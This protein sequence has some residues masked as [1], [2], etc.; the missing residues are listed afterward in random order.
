MT[1]ITI[2]D[3]PLALA[4]LRQLIAQ[5]E[6]L[7]L[8]GEFSDAMKAYNFL[9]K[10]TVDLVFL[11]VEMPGINGLELVDAL[12]NPPLI[13]VVSAKADYALAAFEKHVVDYLV[14]PVTLTRFISAITFA[15]K[16]QQSRQAPKEVTGS[17]FVKADGRW[18][19]V[20]I[21]DIK[22]LQA[23]GDYVRIFTATEKYMV[24]K[25]MKVILEHLPEDKFVRVHRSY[26]VN[27]DHI[28]NIEERTIV[29]DRDVIP[30]SE[31][32]KADFMQHLNLL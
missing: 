19:K 1:C 8:K 32:H 21:R 9:E 16:I 7:Q 4:S 3:N 13:I 28:D 29:I 26:T 6:S 15:Q 14:K 24:N 10:E 11:D 5:T 23:M 31:R 12:A 20:Q 17:L 18:H 27:V 2:D 30:I 22:Y 25:T